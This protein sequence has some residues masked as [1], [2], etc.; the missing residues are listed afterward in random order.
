MH[1]ERK[2]VVLSRNE[3]LDKTLLRENVPGDDFL[4]E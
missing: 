2:I 4:D 1:K 3:C